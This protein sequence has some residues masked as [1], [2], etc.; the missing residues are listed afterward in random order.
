MHAVWDHTLR[1]LSAL[2]GLAMMRVI[3]PRYLASYFKKVYD[4]L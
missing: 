1:H 2:L 4:R 3:G